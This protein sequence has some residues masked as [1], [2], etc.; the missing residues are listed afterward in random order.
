[1]RVSTFAPVGI[2]SYANGDRPF[3]P[4]A[5][6]GHTD[7]D[8]PTHS[9]VDG[10]RATHGH[11]DGDNAAHSHADGD[12]AAD[13]RSEYRGWTVGVPATAAA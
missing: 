2:R 13:L 6:L 10:N 9:Y 12:E 7:V 8:E 11:S 5:A 1:V 4:C 3:G